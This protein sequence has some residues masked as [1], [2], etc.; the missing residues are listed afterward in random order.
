MQSRPCTHNAGLPQFEGARANRGG[1]TVSNIIGTDAPCHVEGRQCTAHDHPQV[2]ARGGGGVWRVQ[3]VGAV[4][5][6]QFTVWPISFSDSDVCATP[7][8][9][10]RGTCLG[11]DS[12]APT[13]QLTQSN[14]LRRRSFCLY[15][16]KC[17]SRSRSTR[18]CEVTMPQM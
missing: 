15:E 17:R 1:K 4:C 11:P 9:C 14:I 6:M 13:P 18:R 3:G 16:M 12:G 8:V 2:P 10:G 5:C 7:E